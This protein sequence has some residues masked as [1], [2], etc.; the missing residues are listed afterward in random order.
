MIN[1]QLREDIL[2]HARTSVNEVCGVIVVKNRR[3]Q[4][5]PCRNIAQSAAEFEIDP[6]DYAKAEDAGDIVAIVHS[7]PKTNV[8]PSQADMVGIERTNKP[9]VICNPITGEFSVTEPTGYE[10]PYIGRE[11]V[12]GVSDCYSIWRDY[13]KREL[14]IDM[15][16]YYRG[17]EWWLKGDNLY[18]DNFAEAGMVEVKDL[19]KHDII[20]MRVVSPVPNHAAVYLGD[21]IILHHVMGRISCKDVYGGWWRKITDRILRHKSLIGA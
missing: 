16:D 5:I 10:L 14:G 2:Q 6:E 3:K 8:T 1:Q 21:N 18:M 7:H 15:K 20:L 13:Y 12:H 11:F 17:H 9:W 4:Y 19:Q